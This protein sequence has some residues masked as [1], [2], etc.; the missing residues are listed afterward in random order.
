VRPW[1][2]KQPVEVGPL[3]TKELRLVVPPPCDVEVHLLDA[4][5]GV[6]VPDGGNLWWYVTTEHADWDFFYVESQPSAVPGIWR[7]T[8]PIGTLA[9]HAWDE[10]YEAE[11]VEVELK[12][13]KNRIDLKA[14]P[15]FS[16]KLALKDGTIPVPVDEDMEAALRAAPLDGDGQVDS[17]SRDFPSQIWFTKAGRYRLTFPAIEGYEP[18]APIEVDIA[19]GK[20]PLIEVALKRR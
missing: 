11:A 3:G 20:I 2:W 18:I 7:F 9:V 6:A 14:S 16:C 10:L 13:G 4:A 12:P 1:G 19:A 17:V 15:N 5:S 8:A